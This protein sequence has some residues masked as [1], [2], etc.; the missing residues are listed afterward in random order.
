VASIDGH[1]DITGLAEAIVLAGPGS[2]TLTLEDGRRLAFQ[3]T[4]SGGGIV[5]REWLP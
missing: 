5:G 4:G 2:L 1:I 3:L